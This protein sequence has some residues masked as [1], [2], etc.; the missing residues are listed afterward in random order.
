[1]KRIPALFAVLV[2]ISAL[3]AVCGNSTPAVAAPSEITVALHL[4]TNSLEPLADDTN[5]NYAIAYHIYDRLVRFDPDSN[6]WLPA[7]A[8][9]WRRVDDMTMEF[10]INL[11]YKFQNGEQL[12]MDDVVFSL[13]RLRD[14]PKTADSGNLIDSITYEGTTL[15][16]KAVSNA[17]TIHTRVLSTAVIV[18]KKHVESGGDVYLAPIGTGPYAVT[19]FT[20]GASATL[21]VWDGYPFEKPKIDK[22]NFIGI[23]ENSSRYMALE[24][25]DVH[26][27]HSITANEYRLAQQ[28]DRITA[29][30]V[31]SRRSGIFVFNCELPPFDRVNVRRALMHAFNREA[32]CALLGGRPQLKSPIFGGYDDYYIEPTNLPEYDLDKARQ[33][34]AEEGFNESNPLSIVMIGYFM[35]PGVE[36]FQSALRSI[37]V[38]LILNITEHSVY[39]ANEAAG[40]FGMEFT[41]N[42][43][44][45]SSPLMD[46]DRFDYTSMRG[47]R[48]ISYFYHERVQELVE[49]MRTPL[50]QQTFRELNVELNELLGWEVPMVGIM[51]QPIFAAADARLTGVVTDRGQILSFRQASFTR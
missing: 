30:T 35:D 45:G 1:M 28:N 23:P 26:Y 31:G 40:N 6:E 33:M 8:S 50:D 38:E 18:N 25:G 29:I 44:R 7:V 36:I 21:E 37:G 24:A 34:L 48:N 9:S 47:V 27:A 19:E 13:M 22:I 11:D 3:F 4:L 49:L 15:T 51:L 2:L 46:L 12:T 43:N 39:L 32:F 10:E 17:L 14:I 5:Q 16:F 42:T 41:T 20:P